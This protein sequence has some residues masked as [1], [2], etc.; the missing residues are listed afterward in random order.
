MEVDRIF[1]YMKRKF[2]YAR[3]DH[4]MEFDQ[5][6]D[7]RSLFFFLF[8]PLGFAKYK[9][10][11]TFIIKIGRRDFAVLIFVNLTAIGVKV[12]RLCFLCFKGVLSC[13]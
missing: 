12:F 10:S 2:S 6:I 1:T 11:K 7:F 3:M 4:Q 5:G 8:F 13:F 9:T